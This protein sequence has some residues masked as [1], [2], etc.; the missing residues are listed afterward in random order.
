MFTHTDDAKADTC[1]LSPMFLF[2]FS[3]WCAQHSIWHGTTCLSWKLW[4]DCLPC[5]SSLHHYP[6]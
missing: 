2:M 1:L 3:A 6:I 4:T 5:T